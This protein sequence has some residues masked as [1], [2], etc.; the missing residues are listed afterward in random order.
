MTRW[1]KQAAL[2]LALLI[3]LPLFAVPANADADAPDYS[4]RDNWAYYDLGKGKAVDVFLICPTVDTTSPANAMEITDKLKDRFL[5]ALDLEKGIYADTGRLFSPYYRQM[6]INAYTLSGAE[7]AAAEHLAYQDVS[8]AFRWYL[9]HENNGRGLILAGF[10]QGAQMCLELLKEYFGGDSARSRALRDQL[11]TVYAIG[12]R[13]TE[14]MTRAYPQIVPATGET[15]LG[16]VVCFDCEDGTLSDTIIIPAGEKSLS[17]NPLNWKTDASAADKSLNRGAVMGLDAAPIPGLCGGYLGARGELV[18][19]D[20]TPADYP[21]GLD[22]FPEGAY[23]LYD[24]L[25][26][27]TNLKEN[28]AK[29]TAVWRGEEPYRD[30]AVTAW[31]APAVRYVSRAGLMN[32]TSKTT[33]LPDGLLKRGELVTILHRAA[34]E[35]V[36]NYAMSFSD[37]A[38]DRWYTEA[39]RW[40]AGEKLLSGKDDGS[41]GVNDVL[42]REETAAILWRFARYTGMDVSAGEDTNIL[43]YDDVFPMASENIPA[44]QWAVGAGV[45]RGTGVGTLSP[46]A[47]LTRA[48]L[49]AML[50]RMQ[51]AKKAA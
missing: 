25:F 42:S 43:S 23:H 10:S 26:F 28:I 27:F 47:P 16:S 8:A 3:L 39:V 38:A 6:S 12:W 35:P 45:I 11:I 21:P 19:T 40:A 49:A 48:Q 18:V 7:R 31:Y 5:Y 44:M 9:D 24:Y 46:A 37:V 36:V 30:V 20:V 1:K 13:V 50:Q 17:I 14:E 2:C 41:F 22:I 33:F 32:G 4:R 51:P 34:G 29:R 15:D